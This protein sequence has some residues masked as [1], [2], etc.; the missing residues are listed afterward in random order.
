MSAVPRSRVAKPDSAELCH[1][2]R[3]SP[4]ARPGTTSSSTTSSNTSASARWRAVVAPTWPAPTTVARAVAVAVV[5]AGGGGRPVEG[6]RQAGHDFG[7]Q[8]LGDDRGAPAV[9]SADRRVGRTRGGGRPGGPPAGR[10]N[11]SGPDGD[12]RTRKDCLGDLAGGDHHA[13]LVGPVAGQ[14]RQEVAG[15]QDEAPAAALDV[16]D[17]DDSSTQSSPLPRDPVL[18]EL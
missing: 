2:S 3:A 11:G 13:E 12:G 18:F 4:A 14:G 7:P 8:R 9:Q 16:A 15:L 6:R 5:V 10:A 1:R 17:A